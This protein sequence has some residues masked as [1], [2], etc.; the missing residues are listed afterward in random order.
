M[1][2]LREG[3]GQEVERFELSSCRVVPYHMSYH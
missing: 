2:L 3:R 1:A